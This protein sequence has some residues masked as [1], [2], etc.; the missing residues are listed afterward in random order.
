MQIIKKV[1]SS[2]RWFSNTYWIIYNRFRFSIRGYKF[3]NNT[4]LIGKIYLKGRGECVIGDNFRFT[5]GS[6]I[7]P[8]SRN[9]RG[10]I[11]V[12]RGARLCIGNNVGFS[13]VCIWA[14]DSIRIGDNVNVGANVVIM[15]NDAHPIEYMAR[16]DVDKTFTHTKTAAIIIENDVWIGMNSI[17]LKGVS[18]GARTIIGAGSVVTGFIPADCIA[19]GNPCHVVKKLKE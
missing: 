3:G 13:S 5:S 8:I 2:C 19:A 14:N 6:N 18:I 10:S 9:I 1:M 7:N 15:D 17:I 16:R 12:K 4:K 11:Y